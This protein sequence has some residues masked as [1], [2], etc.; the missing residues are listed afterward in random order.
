MSV[1]CEVC[2]KYKKR[3]SAQNFSY[4]TYDADVP[5]NQAQLDIWGVDDLP[6]VQIISDVGEVLHQFPW[7]TFSPAAIHAQMSLLSAK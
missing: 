1:E 4:E 2:E 7:G 6:V 5:E 3:L